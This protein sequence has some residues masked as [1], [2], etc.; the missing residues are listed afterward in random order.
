MLEEEQQEEG[1]R[2][3]TEQTSGRLFHL[4]THTHAHIHTLPLAFRLLYVSLSRLFYLL[5]GFSWPLV[6]VEASQLTAGLYMCTMCQGNAPTDGWTDGPDSLPRDS[7]PIFLFLSR[8]IYN[9]AAPITQLAQGVKIISVPSPL[10]FSTNI[11]QISC[12]TATNSKQTNKTGRNRNLIEIQLASKISPLAPLFKSCTNTIFSVFFNIKKKRKRRERGRM[13]CR[14]S[15]FLIN[16]PRHGRKKTSSSLFFSLSLVKKEKKKM[17]DSEMVFFFFFFSLLTGSVE[18]L[19]IGLSLSL[20]STL[21]RCIFIQISSDI[22]HRLLTFQLL[23][24]LTHLKLFGGLSSFPQTVSISIFSL[25]ILWTEFSLYLFF[26]FYFSTSFILMDSQPSV[27]IPPPF[28]S[29]E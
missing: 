8:I 25:F 4:I 9:A 23:H 13:C 12:L 26:T 28:P 10:L 19:R 16:N 15:A 3:G 27:V 5:S 24:F 21:V 17:R 1:E 22:A 29:S 14:S 7:S 6:S 11:N 2:A 20:M 18:R